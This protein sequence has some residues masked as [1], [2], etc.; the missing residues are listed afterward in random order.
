MDH[1]KKE[2]MELHIR[3]DSLTYS[4]SS[5]E[6]RSLYSKARISGQ[7]VGELINKVDESKT[8]F[9]EKL[10]VI[11]QG[12]KELYEDLYSKRSVRFEECLLG[13]KDFASKLGEAADKK[14][15][16]GVRG[17]SIP[18]GAEILPAIE[19]ALPLILKKI[20]MQSIETPD[21]RIEC[22]KSPVAKIIFTAERRGDSLLIEVSDD[23]RGEKIGAGDVEVKNVYDRIKTV[24][25]KLEAIA[26]ENIGGKYKMTFPIRYSIINCLLLRIKDN[27]YAAPIAA[28]EELTKVGEFTSGNSNTEK[29]NFKIVQAGKILELEKITNILNEESPAII[30]GDY[31]SKL[32]LVF[33][34]FIG[35]AEIAPLDRSEFID[36]IPFVLAGAIYQDRPIFILDLEKLK[37]SAF[38]DL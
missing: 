6:D 28:V 11:M 20:I 25:G 35:S 16:I 30:I 24:N 12:S 1:I 18:I 7:S 23:G 29:S 4:L 8:D 22:G 3:I 38:T 19:S 9:S 15:K 36:N 33:D 17:A 26:G 14:I 32:V 37:R 13:L 21:E 31:D 34:E 2:L 5:H 10:G 27:L